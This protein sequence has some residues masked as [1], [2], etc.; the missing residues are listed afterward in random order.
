MDFVK[1]GRDK[2]KYFYIF[3]LIMMFCGLPKKGKTAALWKLY[4]CQRVHN[5]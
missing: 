5:V 3:Y 1:G 4:T 2:L